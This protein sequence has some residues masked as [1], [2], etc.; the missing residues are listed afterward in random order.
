MESL[1][2]LN[3]SQNKLTTLPEEMGMLEDLVEVLASSNNIK[4][5]LLYHHL[6]LLVRAFIQYCLV[7]FIIFFLHLQ[8]LPAALGGGKS[9]LRTIDLSDND[10]VEYN[11]KL[12]GNTLGLRNLLLSGNRLTHLPENLDELSLLEVIFHLRQTALLL[13]LTQLLFYS[14]F[15]FSKKMIEHV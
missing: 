10:L 8:T 11:D 3:V 15:F 4:V 9:G 12:V 6:L 7:V 5:C 1:T 2:S 13:L 14:S